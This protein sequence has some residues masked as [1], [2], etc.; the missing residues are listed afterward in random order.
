MIFL[1]FVDSFFL[2]L[3]Q[4]EDDEKV[5]YEID[6]PAYDPVEFEGEILHNAEWADKKPLESLNFNNVDGNVDRRSFEGIY[7]LGPDGK[8]LN[9]KGRTGVVGRGILGKVRR[10]SST[11]N[12]R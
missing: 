10:Q 9:I 6:Y 12:P 7:R 5:F 2:T 4:L 3:K 1:A 11:F 8:P